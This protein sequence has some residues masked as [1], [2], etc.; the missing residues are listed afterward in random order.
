MSEFPSIPE[1]AN[2]LISLIQDA[3]LDAVSGNEIFVT[4]EEKE[5]RLSICKKCPEYHEEQM[6]CKNCGCFLE[7]KV[8]FTAS[9]CPLSHWEFSETHP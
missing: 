3:I 6:R 5:R 8:T 7:N 2:N 1:Q 9:K 4:E